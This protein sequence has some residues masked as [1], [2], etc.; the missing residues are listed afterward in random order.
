MS[1]T[2]IGKFYLQ[3][4]STLH[5]DV[6]CISINFI[7]IWI[8]SVSILYV[9]SYVSCFPVMQK[10]Y[11]PEMGT[12]FN[13]KS[14]VNILLS[15]TL[16]TQGLAITVHNC[17]DCHHSHQYYHYHHHLSLSRLGHMTSGAHSR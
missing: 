14:F 4:N 10:V 13:G 5:H 2:Y 17:S 1:A 16:K 9:S 15:N 3:N 6:Y 11:G 7:L 12:V 8:G